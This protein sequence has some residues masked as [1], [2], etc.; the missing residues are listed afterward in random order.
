MGVLPTTVLPEN[1]RESSFEVPDG[2]LPLGIFDRVFK[3]LFVLRG[4]DKCGGC[5]GC[6]GLEC[7]LEC[8]ISDVRREGNAG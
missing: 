7:V 5:G 4:I 1:A 6:D 8:A 3:L 2:P